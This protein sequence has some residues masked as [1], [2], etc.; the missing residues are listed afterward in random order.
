[1]IKN[2][3]SMLSWRKKTVVYQLY[4][5]SFYGLNGDC[6]GDLE[7]IIL[8]LDYLQD[9]GIEAISFSHFFANHFSITDV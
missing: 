9:L 4:P 6:I 1:M 2:S 5:R 3:V 8:K 7:G